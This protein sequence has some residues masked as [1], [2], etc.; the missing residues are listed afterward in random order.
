MADFDPAT[1]TVTWGD[2]SDSNFYAIDSGTY[3][4]KVERNEW[5]QTGENSAD[6]GK[7]MAQVTFRIS[8]ARVTKPAKGN[9]PAEVV[10]ESRTLPQYFTFSK[11]FAVEQAHK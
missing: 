11:P 3:A 5:K 7:P 2:R 8:E 9:K 1:F 6:P 4:V 10:T